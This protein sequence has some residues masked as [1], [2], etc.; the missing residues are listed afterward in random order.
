MTFAERPKSYS[1]KTNG[2]KIEQVYY[3]LVVLRSANSRK[4]YCDYVAENAQ[5]SSAT[6]LKF[7]ETKGSCYIPAALKL[8]E[9]KPIA[10]LLYIAQLGSFSNFALLEYVQSFKSQN[11]S[12][13]SL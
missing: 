8:F 7:L 10:E 9:A 2:N 4:L 11:V 3:F 1:W 6:I 5:R 12:L 13:V